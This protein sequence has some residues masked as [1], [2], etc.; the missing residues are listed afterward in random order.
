M[1]AATR[2]F[3]SHATKNM[4]AEKAVATMAR[5]FGGTAAAV[6]D[7]IV[8]SAAA[9]LRTLLTANNGNLDVPAFVGL[10]VAKKIHRLLADILRDSQRAGSTELRATVVLA[11]HELLGRSPTA[12]HDLGQHVVEAVAAA[13][14][15]ASTVT[16]T[17]MASA[18]LHQAATPPLT[19]AVTDMDGTLKQDIQARLRGL[20]SA[21]PVILFMKGTPGRPRCGFSRAAVELLQT[22]KIVFDT[23][24]ILEDSSVREGESAN[25]GNT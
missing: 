9:S 1:T 12:S 5:V 10:L 4:S 14:K 16:D 19:A 23:F 3:R 21:K 18:T 15:N 11:L 22:K 20:V 25:A 6:E 24:D 13:A 2:T 17:A 8:T 7:A